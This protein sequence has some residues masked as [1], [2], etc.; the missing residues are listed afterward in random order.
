MCSPQALSPE[1]LK[2]SHYPYGVHI[3]RARTLRRS[4]RASN[5]IIAAVE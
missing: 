4:I 5:G 2:H 3:T 1:A